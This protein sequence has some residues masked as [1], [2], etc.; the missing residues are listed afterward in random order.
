MS[1]VIVLRLIPSLALHTCPCFPKTVPAHSHAMIVEQEVE[2]KLGMSL[3]ALIG[4]AK[5]RHG[6]SPRAPHSGRSSGGN[7]D[8]QSSAYSAGGGRGPTSP[9]S[10]GGRGRGRALG[11]AGG[12][13]RDRNES[14]GR[15]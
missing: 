2:R 8:H 7:R 6:P 12:Q 11:Q 4:A 15:C 3:D 1:S 9:H 13:K 14:E 5:E 10:R